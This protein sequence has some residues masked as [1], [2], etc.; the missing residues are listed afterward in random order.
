MSRRLF[1]SCFIILGL[2]GSAFATS[3]LSSVDHWLRVD[4]RSI[5]PPR[6][7][8]ELR[9]AIRTNG[10]SIQGLVRIPGGI[11]SN[12]DTGSGTTV[13]DLINVGGKIEGYAGIV[14]VEVLLKQPT[15][16]QSFDVWVVDYVE[17]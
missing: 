10:P 14:A 8:S 6:N 5:T 17:K 13:V 3:T 1:L 16:D 9:I 4:L 12:F 15:P 7:V 2:V 11:A